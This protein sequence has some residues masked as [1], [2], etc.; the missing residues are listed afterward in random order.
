MSMAS[1]DRTWRKK[2]DAWVK[3][4]LEVVIKSGRADKVSKVRN[5]KKSLSS[6]RI[7]PY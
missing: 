6:Y 3:K 1:A 2:R 7:D 4:K 5:T